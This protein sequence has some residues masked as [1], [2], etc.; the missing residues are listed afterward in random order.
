MNRY[1][2]V[3]RRS[4]TTSRLLDEHK[5]LVV[6]AFDNA[7]SLI[8]GVTPLTTVKNCGQMQCNVA[9]ELKRA[10]SW[11]PSHFPVLGLFLSRSPLLLSGTM[12]HLSARSRIVEP[13]AQW[14]ELRFDLTARKINVAHGFTLMDV[15][16]DEYL[17][18]LGRI[19]CDLRLHAHCLARRLTIF[20]QFRK[21]LGLWRRRVE[22]EH[23]TLCCTRALAYASPRK[24]ST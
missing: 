19:G 7:E 2:T 22:A 5:P 3:H 9:V 24:R 15:T 13:L 12:L 14:T 11:L 4:L 1:Q 16:S 8:D 10:L 6:I 20:L 18:H 17:C 21:P 23:D